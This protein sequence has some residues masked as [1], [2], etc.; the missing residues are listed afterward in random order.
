MGL[1]SCA[2]SEI[3]T[4]KWFRIKGFTSGLQDELFNVG[5]GTKSRSEWF[6]KRIRTKILE[7]GLEWEADWVVEAR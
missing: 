5:E 4:L 2:W 1:L 6:V 7:G 3:H